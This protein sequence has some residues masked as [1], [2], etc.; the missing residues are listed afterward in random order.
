[1]KAAFA[2]LLLAVI[3]AVPANAAI[4]GL[5]RISL[6]GS[7]YVRLAEWAE[8]SGF[9]MTWRGKNDPIEL[10]NQTAS[11]SFATDSRN[12]RKAQ[13]SGVTVMLNLPV[14]NRNGVPL[15]SLA[16]VQKSLEPVLFPH[17]SAAQV[18]TICLDPGHGGRGI[19]A[20]STDHCSRKKYTLLLAQAVEKLLQDAGF[21]VVLTRT[22]DVYVDLPERPA[23]ASRAGADLF[24]S[25]HYNSDATRGVNGVEIH[26][27]PP[28]GMN[29]SNAGG[30]KS[31]DPAYAGNA[32][33][34]RNMLLAY[35]MIKNITPK[36]P[37][38]EIGIKRSHLAVLRG[39]AHMPAI[40][41]EGGF[42]TDAQ[43]AK[44][45][46]TRDFPPAHGAKH[47]E[48]NSGLQG[49]RGDKAGRTQ[50]RRNQTGGRGGQ[51]V[52]AASK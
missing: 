40:L 16:D 48:W 15:I 41:I 49:S 10:T 31:H 13:I 4:Q 35:E 12:A 51:V 11:L 7:D 22:T 21:K 32:E 45:S 30:G 5:E 29:S 38:E 28:A 43:D 20:I 52:G 42:M 2:A 50:T 14:I 8:V 18:R 39:E 27:L 23:V 19:R 6:E 9:N 25:L 37:L 34:D 24:V 3:L 47:R 33:D 17:K 26:C 44:K 46:T 36:L 1:M